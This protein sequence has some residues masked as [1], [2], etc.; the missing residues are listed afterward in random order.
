VVCVS[1]KDRGDE[2]HLS[3]C[4]R[5]SRVQVAAV[6][7]IVVAVVVVRIGMVHNVMAGNPELH[8]NMED[9]D[10]GFIFG[11]FTFFF[12]FFC[13]SLHPPSYYLSTLLPSATVLGRDL[14]VVAWECLSGVCQNVCVLSV[15]PV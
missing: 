13:V 4:L 6:E 8:K 5:Y 10:V 15:S 12:V 3:Q 14:G 7:V 9:R 2:R 1:T 11:F